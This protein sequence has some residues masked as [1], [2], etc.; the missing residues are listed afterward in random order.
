M[1]R[2]PVK[3]RKR[4]HPA[5]HVLLDQVERARQRAAERPPETRERE[6]IGLPLWA[7]EDLLGS[8]VDGTIQQRVIDVTRERR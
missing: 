3:R 8:I 7:A 2:Q 4:S 5:V 6:S 1:G